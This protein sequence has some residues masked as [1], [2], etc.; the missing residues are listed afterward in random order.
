MDHVCD[1][2]LT[3]A[4]MCSEA[5]ISLSTW[6]RQFRHTLP[7]VRLSPKRVGVRASAWRAEL[8]RRTSGQ[9]GRSDGDAR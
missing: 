2:I 1:P 6:R 8:A 9:G 7:V 3:P 4:D 5:K